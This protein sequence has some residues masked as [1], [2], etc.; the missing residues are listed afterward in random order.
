MAEE[1]I[2]VENTELQQALQI[3]QFTGS[4]QRQNATMRKY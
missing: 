2:D 3:I 4:R 1:T